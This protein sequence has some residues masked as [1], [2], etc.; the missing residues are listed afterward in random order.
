MTREEL[1]TRLE[2]FTKADGVTDEFLQ[3]AKDIQDGS[4]TI[5]KILNDAIKELNKTNKTKETK[6]ITSLSDF[7][8]P[9]IE[10][11]AEVIR[12]MDV[13]AYYYF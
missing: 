4:D 11:T 8:A 10:E 5:K 9:E 6:K 7:L 12:S 3:L 2:A 1:A 13:K